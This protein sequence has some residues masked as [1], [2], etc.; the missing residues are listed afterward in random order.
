[1]ISLGEVGAEQIVP[2]PNNKIKHRE[3]AHGGGV[4]RTYHVTEH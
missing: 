3:E 2:I 4:T 1:V